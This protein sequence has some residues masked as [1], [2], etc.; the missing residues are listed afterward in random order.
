MA[1][2]TDDD[3]AVD[4]PTVPEALAWLHELKKISYSAENDHSLQLFTKIMAADALQKIQESMEMAARPF[5]KS[6]FPSTA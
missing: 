6:T 1:D 3:D 5:P 4:L 2:Q